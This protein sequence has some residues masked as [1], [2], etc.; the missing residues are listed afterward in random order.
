MGDGPVGRRSTTAS[1]VIK[2]FAQA[3]ARIR[4]LEEEITRHKV[5]SRLLAL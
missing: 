4:E 1:K 3:L 5:L 2:N